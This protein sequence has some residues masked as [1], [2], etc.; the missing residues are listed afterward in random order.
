[1]KSFEKFGVQTRGNFAESNMKRRIGS[2]LR[3]QA[4]L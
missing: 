2:Q 4:L 3:I 1:M